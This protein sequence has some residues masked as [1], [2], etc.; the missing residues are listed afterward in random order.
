MLKAVGGL[1]ATLHEPRVFHV[2]RHK[3]RVQIHVCAL[4]HTRLRWRRL[5]SCVVCL[6]HCRIGMTRDGE[7]LLGGETPNDVPC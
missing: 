3:L 2:T 4:R 7:L 5:I 1:L 6:G